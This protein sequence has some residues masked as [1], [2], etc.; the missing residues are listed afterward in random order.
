[1]QRADLRRPASD[2][3]PREAELLD[4]LQTSA[5]PDCCPRDLRDHVAACTSCAELEAIVRPLL[6]EHHRTVSTA[7]VPPSGAVWWRAQMRARQEAARKAARPISIA[8]AIGV[9][10]AL[11]I[12]AG[13][14]T[15]L[16]PS[17]REIA[18]TAGNAGWLTWA[19]SVMPSPPWTSFDSSFQSMTLES[20][21]PATMAV[22]LAL[23]AV[24]LLAPVAIYL[25][26]AGD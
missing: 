2:T 8:Q 10:C 14:F 15:L 13:G 26:S 12:L 25:A 5:W 1:V 6:D 17:L 20:L 19:A 4:A 11:G 3:C 7:S 24:L 22:L 9:A 23:T 18:D 16:A 21:A